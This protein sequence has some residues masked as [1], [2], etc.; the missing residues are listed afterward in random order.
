[1][2]LG[3]CLRA[4]RGQVLLGI[5]ACDT[6]LYTGTFREPRSRFPG[7]CGGR[8]LRDLACLSAASLYERLAQ[9]RVP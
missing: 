6:F 1:M 8:S 4:F 5:H 7:A 9:T 2:L 3:T